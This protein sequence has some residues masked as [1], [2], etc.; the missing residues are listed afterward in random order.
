MTR[1]DRAGLTPSQTVGPFLHLGLVLPAARHAVPQG[2]AGALRIGGTVRDGT[3]E[4]VT[5]AVVETWQV[6]PAGSPHRGLARCWTGPDG[7]WD[8]L[9][10]RPD[11][12]PTPDGSATEAPHLDVSVFARGLLDRVVTRVYL[13]EDA[14]VEGPGGHAHDPALRRVPEH[15]RATLVA[16]RVADLDYRFDIRLQGEDETVFFDL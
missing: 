11:P 10:V 9:T 14:R 8:V 5:D 2:T 6:L 3:G 1:P 4:P 15:R 12:L 13:P 7:S 16:V